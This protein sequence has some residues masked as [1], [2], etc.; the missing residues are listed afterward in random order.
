MGHWVG[1]GVHASKAAVGV[2][3]SVLSVTRA[4]L[5]ALLRT[6]ST[7]ISFRPALRAPASSLPAGTTSSPTERTHAR[8]HAHLPGSANPPNKWGEMEAPHLQAAHDHESH[9]R[10]VHLHLDAGS[11]HHLRLPLQP[12]VDLRQGVGW[13]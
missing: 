6:Q 8:T 4:L 1:V 11:P 7:L 12:Q 9:A 13:G 3:G 5:P 2:C 10:H